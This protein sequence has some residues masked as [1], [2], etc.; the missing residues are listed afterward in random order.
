MTKL[1]LLAGAFM[2][3]TILSPIGAI[4]VNIPSAD[5]KI[6]KDAYINY[7]TTNPDIEKD[8]ANYVETL[9]LTDKANGINKNEIEYAKA[10]SIYRAQNYHNTV[11]SIHDQYNQIRLSFPVAGKKSDY[12]IGHYKNPSRTIEDYRVLTNNGRHNLEIEYADYKD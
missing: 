5:S 4:D 8:V 11:I 3:S 1:P 12:D 7:Q 9:K 10:A 2:M 6:S